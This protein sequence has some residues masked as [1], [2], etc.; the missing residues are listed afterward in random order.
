MFSKSFSHFNRPGPTEHV[1]ILGIYHQLFS[2]E[3]T[4]TL[5]RSDIN[6]N[7]IGE[8]WLIFPTNRLVSNP[9]L[10]CK[11]SA[12]PAGLPIHQNG[13]NGLHHDVHH[14]NSYD[15][16]RSLPIMLSDYSSVPFLNFAWILGVLGFS[17]TKY[18]CIRYRF[19]NSI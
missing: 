6:P 16:T 17:E 8:G 14:F 19:A 10:I 11:C 9:H 12:G 7:P 13:M 15:E 3:T 2:T 4:E 18:K 5:T 1:G